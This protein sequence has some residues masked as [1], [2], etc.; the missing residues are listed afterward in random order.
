LALTRT[1][2]GGRRKPI[3]L[4]GHQYGPNWGLPGM[5]G[6]EQVGAAV[7]FLGKEPLAPG[8]TARALII[9]MLPAALPLW[10]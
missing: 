10:Q 6:T 9:P 8:E 3:S 1:E 4:G 2:D 5:E 7:H